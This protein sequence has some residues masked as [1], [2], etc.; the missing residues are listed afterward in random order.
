MEIQIGNT[1]YRVTFRHIIR[2]EIRT[3]ELL[4]RTVARADSQCHPPDVFNEREG[5]IKAFRKCFQVLKFVR[6]VS[7]DLEEPEQRKALWRQFFERL[8]PRP[9]AKKAAKA[10]PETAQ[11]VRQ[12]AKAAEEA[13]RMF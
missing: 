10:E 4:S 13:L 11:I 2:C 5:K 7:I 12:A 1:K 8:D 6:G 3:R 9:K